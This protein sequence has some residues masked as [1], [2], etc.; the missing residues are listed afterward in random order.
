MTAYQ[1]ARSGG[2]RRARCRCGR[3]VLRQLVGHRAALDVTA[4]DEFMSA[5]D[6]EA[7]RTEHRLHWCVRET[8]D[9]LDLRWADC[10]R[11]AAPCPHPHVISHVC[12]APPDAPAPRAR[13][14]RKSSVPEGQLTL[15]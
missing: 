12:T 8:R 7:L 3:P 1:P 9:G 2:A 13:R 11:R 4:D 6:A 10:R 14:P 15:G 5:A